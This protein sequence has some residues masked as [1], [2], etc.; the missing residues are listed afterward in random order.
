MDRRLLQCPVLHPSAPR[1]PAPHHPL[2]FQLG[3]AQAYSML[4]LRHLLARGS[5]VEGAAA[6]AAVQSGRLR[7][8]AAQHLSTAAEQPEQGELR[9]LHGGHMLLGCRGG[10]PAETPTPPRPH[11]HADANVLL[12]Q[13][14]TE[15]GSRAAERLRKARPCGAGGGLLSTACCTCH[16]AATVRRP[17]APAQRSPPPTNMKCG[18]CR[19]ARRPASCS[20]SR[21]RSRS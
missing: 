13:P 16:P 10:D 9:A 5:A 18:W 6:L 15:G 11:V 4:V 7:Q 2:G 12:A 8:L 1:T 20:R 21:G 3:S 14:R 19:R 17:T